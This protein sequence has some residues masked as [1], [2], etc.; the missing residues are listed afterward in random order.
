MK[1]L[2]L[3]TLLIGTISTPVVAIVSCSSSSSEEHENNTI[4]D[5]PRGV[6]T[7]PMKVLTKS[8]KTQEYYNYEMAIDIL[9]HNKIY[10]PRYLF[11]K[12]SQLDESMF[13][14]AYIF[15][16]VLEIKEI[17]QTWFKDIKLIVKIVV[18][19]DENGIAKLEITT[20]S[21]FGNKKFYITI[22]NLLKNSNYHDYLDEQWF[23]SLEWYSVAADG[24]G[25]KKPWTYWLTP[26]K[27]SFTKKSIKTW[28]FEYLH[29][30]PDTTLHLNSYFAEK[31]KD[32]SKVIDKGELLKV[33]KDWVG[34]NDLGDQL[35]DPKIE[36][37]GAKFYSYDD[38]SSTYP[39]DK[40][41]GQLTRGWR[42]GGVGVDLTLKRGNVIKEHVILIIYGF[43]KQES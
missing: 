40:T 27:T 36:I 10:K 6:R 31:N 13:T 9:K 2:L 23:N 38:G 3:R 35:N 32:N 18:R 17:T 25:P 5:E 14:R 29:K 8:T 19:D 21:K 4:I 37:L 1:K 24:F 20:K 26:V 11:K 22:P 30:Y 42:N 7:T 15:W 43:S 33:L 28:L 34:L 41:V 12:P 16:N 39:N